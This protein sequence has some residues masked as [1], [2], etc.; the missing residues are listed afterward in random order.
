[1]KVSTISVCPKGIVLKLNGALDS[2]TKPVGEV[3]QLVC[4]HFLLLFQ[5][6]HPYEYECSAMLNAYSIEHSAAARAGKV[7]VKIT[8]Y[9][10]KVIISDTIHHYFKMFE[11]FCVNNLTI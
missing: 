5:T 9:L 8:Y 10:I 2:F 6:R 3:C 11:I 7:T 1:M 4:V